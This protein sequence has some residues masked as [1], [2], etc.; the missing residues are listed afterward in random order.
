[1]AFHR[2]LAR[3]PSAREEESLKQFFEGQLTYYRGKPDEAKKLIAV[4]LHAAPAAAD[5]ATLAAWISVARVLLNLNETI[6]RY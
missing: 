6:V 2:L 1:D 3:P 4:G 5:P